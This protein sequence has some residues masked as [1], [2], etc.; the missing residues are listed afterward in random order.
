MCSGDF[1]PLPNVLTASND[2][3]CSV[4]GCD[5][6]VAWK[7]FAGKTPGKNVCSTCGAS[8]TEMPNEDV[9]CFSLE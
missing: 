8:Y 7:R 5:A 4:W 6:Q 2:M 3:K 1:S 9:Q